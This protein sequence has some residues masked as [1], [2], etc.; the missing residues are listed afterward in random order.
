MRARSSGSA[1]LESLGSTLAGSAASFCSQCTGSS[2]R[3]HHVFGIEAEPFARCSSSSHSASS[4]SALPR[5]HRSRRSGRNS[6]RSARRPC[7][8]RARTPSAAG[9]RPDTICPARNAAARPAQSARCSLRIS[10]SASARLVGPTAA[11]FHSGDSRSS[12][13]T[14]VGS[15]PMVRRTSPALRSAS[16]CSPSAVE[17]RPGFV[18]ERPG[19]PRR[20]ADALDAHLEAELDIGEAGGARDR[21]RRAVMRRGGDGN[22]PLAGQHARGDVEPDPAR[23][24]QID[25]GPGVQIG[26]I[27]L[28]LARPFDRIDVGAQLDQIAGDEARGEPEMTEDLDQQPRRVAAGAG[29]AGQRLFRRLNARLHPDDV[30]DLFL[31]FRVELDQ[32]IDGAVGLAR[33]VLQVGGELRPLAPMSPDRARVRS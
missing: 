26:E 12:T 5:R 15:P 7:A 6:S 13:E 25:L 24:R 14:K 29:A 8:N 9:F 22:M 16:T 21:R 31:Q 2:I 3:R 18:G 11:I 32:E 19:D 10:S 27:A 30:A 20:F 28:D 23:A 1:S 4:T 17:A 33:N